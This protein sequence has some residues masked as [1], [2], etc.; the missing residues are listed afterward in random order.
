MYII[1]NA[2]RCISRAKGRNFLIGIIVFIIALSACIGLSIRQAAES[3][4][5]DT[6]E[7]LSITA[8]IS[9]DTS[10]F[11]QNMRPPES[12]GTSEPPQ[13]FDRSEY[14][15]QKGAIQNLTLEEYQKYATA[16]SVKDF[17]YTATAS[18]NGSD[19]FLPVSNEAEET[20]TEQMP[21]M[22]GFGGFG[23][24]GGGK[25]RI[26][27]IQSDFS[28]EGVSSEKAMTAFDSGASM[29]SGTVFDEGTEAYECI[30]TEELAIYNDVSVGSVI[31]LTNPNNE[32]ETYNLSVVGIFSGSSSEQS[33]FSMMGS[34]AIDP[35][36]K[37]YMS[38]NAL[39]KIISYSENNA[40]TETDE[41][42]GREFSTALT[43]QLNCTYL[44]AN[45]EDYHSFET[46]VRELGLDENY[47]VSSTDITSFEE[48]LVPLE[49]LSTT[50]GY[51]LIVILIIGVVI[52]VVLNIF[53]I[54]E[55]KYEI[56]V[57]TAMGMKKG[58]V[59]M[60]FITEIFV[61][62]LFAVIIGIGIG[63]VSSVPVTNALLQNQIEAKTESENQLEVNLGRGEMSAPPN[64]PNGGGNGMMGGGNGMQK[65]EDFGKLFE[66]T[67]TDNYISEINNAM[68]FTVV[69]Q[70]F[71]IAMLLTLASG[72]VSMLFVM[73]YEPLKILANRD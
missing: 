71:G 23:G 27:G 39:K 65:F 25:D 30:I 37:I 56:G 42:T 72:I 67:K 64:M 21:N 17:Y 50:A 11:M 28:I 47:I 61:V 15:T 59:A 38:Y 55:R 34:T 69:L 26:K 58:K 19:S 44:F 43:E 10:S 4:K 63:A 32:E 13:N 24:M 53:N 40:T 48:S 60:Q 5:K 45:T 73:R 3:A 49:T 66:P 14:K 29:S 54:R 46:Q 51:F 9:F 7:S 18:L 68:N 2:F 20:Q 16:K 33:S 41:N 22:G 12:G 57:L 6:A 35:V 36:N 31:T 70:M 62:T 8:T 1:K 52:L